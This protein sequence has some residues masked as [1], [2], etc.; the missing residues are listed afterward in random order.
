MI[1]MTDNET[2]IQN[3]DQAAGLRGVAAAGGSPRP[4]AMGATR[5]VAIGSGKGGVGKTVVSV[6]ISMALSERG[7]RV[8]LFDGDMGLANVDLQ[9]GL[10]P[11]Y[12][13]Q[14]VIFGQCPLEHACIHVEQGPDVLVSAS[15]APELADISP[16]RRRVFIED[17]F[18]FASGYD[19][20]I[21]DTGAGIG[22]STTDF[23]AAC[24]EV[25]VVLM[26]EP[27][28]LMDAYALIKTLHLR[29]G[30]QGTGVI[31]NMVDSL[32]EG[33][34]LFKQLDDIARRFIGAPLSLEGIIVYD[35]RVSEA[36]RR[37]NSIVQYAGNGAVAQCLR[38]LAQRLATRTRRAAPRPTLE[39]WI[40]QWENSEFLK[41]TEGPPTS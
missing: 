40:A 34:R 15:G 16:A 26:N 10:T 17:L 5:C 30:G 19:Y 14:D 41:T 4:H 2:K 33:E 22:R 12:T 38:E 6:G 37:Q 3:A 20:F 27:T 29:T 32:D 31:V 28:S 7:H 1:V 39:Q 23:L 21:V 18:R 11:E 9:L 13:L 8:L 25:L 24:P 36:I 35:R